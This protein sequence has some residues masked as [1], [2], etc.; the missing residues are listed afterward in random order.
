[1]LIKAQFKNYYQI[2]TRFYKKRTNNILRV[3]FL[4][5]KK[6]RFVESK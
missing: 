5:K 4:A 1:M 6:M 3:P 2:F